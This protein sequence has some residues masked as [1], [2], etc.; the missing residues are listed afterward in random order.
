MSKS[1]FSKVPG[2]QKGTPTEVFPKHLQTN[3]SKCTYIKIKNCKCEGRGVT[4]KT[5]CLKSRSSRLQVFFEIGVLK[6]FVNITGK[7]LCWSLFLIKF[8]VLTPATLLKRDFNK[9]VFLRNLQ[10][11]KNIVF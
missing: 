1:L 7:Y 4:G 9:K 8:Q 2:L 6:I 3:A 5:Y 11:F 10:S